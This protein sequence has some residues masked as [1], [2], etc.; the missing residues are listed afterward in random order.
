MAQRDFKLML[1]TGSDARPGRIWTE[2]HPRRGSVSFEL[3]P[4]RS[5]TACSARAGGAKTVSTSRTPAA[6]AALFGRRVQISQ[7][8][9]GD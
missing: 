3:E 2:V 9:A 6:L 8:G 7:H 4:G 5:Q 1:K